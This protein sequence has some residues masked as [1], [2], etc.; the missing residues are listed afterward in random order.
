MILLLRAEFQAGDRILKTVS[1]LIEESSQNESVAVRW[2]G[3]EFILYMP[4]TGSD[5]AF[6]QLNKIIDSIRT[7][8]VEFENMI[9]NVTVTVGMCTGNDLKDYEEVIKRADALLYYGKRNG[10]NC[11]CR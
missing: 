2:G 3:E 4:Q 6:E 9:L 10:K 1:K 7:T 11:V 8:S 5:K